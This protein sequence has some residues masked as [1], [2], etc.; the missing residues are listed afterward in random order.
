MMERDGRAMRPG[1]GK[2]GLP[3]GP[4]LGRSEGTFTQHRRL[5]KLRNALEASPAGIELG[6]L[7]TMLSVSL[8]SVRRYLREL[9]RFTELE[10]IPTVPGGPH[11]WRIKPSERGRTIALRRTQAYLLLLGR[12]LYEAF[13]GSALY[14]ELDVAMRQVLQLAQRPVRIGTRGEIPH[15]GR[16]EGRMRFL[17]PAARAHGD[18]AEDVD[19]LFQ[20]VSELRV[21]RLRYRAR[22]HEKPERM[23]L[24]PYAM[25]LQDGTFFA[26]GLHVEARTVG[27]FALDKMSDLLSTE[28]E[29][30][31]LP[32]DFDV[33]PFL[34]GELGVFPPDPGASRV[35]V[36]F[37]ARAAERVRS[38]RI[39]P[40]QRIATSPDGRVRV[41]FFAPDLERVKAWVLGFGDA[42]RV[43]EPPALA[44]EICDIL[45]RAAARYK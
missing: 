44:E 39:H 20:A 40:T 8:R 9:D 10:S 21:L 27:V 29:L 3:R 16:L 1:R 13:R 19:R 15:E 17:P 43:I 30:F 2:Q 34:H 31:P 25:V 45:E 37:D 42:A 7:A 41:S 33:E 26:I 6:D 5:D 23:V 14:D 11:V 4:R 18:R 24:H 12:P 35:L 22:P 32:E 28:D 38:R 36:E